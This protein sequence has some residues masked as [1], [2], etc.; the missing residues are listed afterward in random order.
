MPLLLSVFFLASGCGKECVDEAGNV[1]ASERTWITYAPGASIRFVN[2]QG[3][4]AHLVAEGIEDRAHYGGGSKGECGKNF[5]S[6]HQ[7]LSGL[8]LSSGFEL[9]VVHDRATGNGPGYVGGYNMGAITPTN[10]VEV[11][12]V[13]YDQV[14]IFADSLYYFSKAAGLIKVG[15]RILIP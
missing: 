1:T 14:Y 8:G 7:R 13:T 2:A 6:L 9:M 3:D 4:T 5:H 10:G 15:D 11:N 12:G